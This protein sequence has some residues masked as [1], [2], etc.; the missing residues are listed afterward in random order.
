MNIYCFMFFAN[1]L[2]LA[3]YFICI[4]PLRNDVRQKAN[5]NNFFIQVQNE[6]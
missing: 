1:E 3:V 6:S 5:L 4:F 2:L